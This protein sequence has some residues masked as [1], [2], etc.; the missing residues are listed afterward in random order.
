MK[1][2]IMTA[3]VFSEFYGI[4]G[5]VDAA[6]WEAAGSDEWVDVMTRELVSGANTEVR[7]DQFQKRFLQVA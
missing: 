7:V 5:I 3:G 4:Y 6:Q 2:A 1:N